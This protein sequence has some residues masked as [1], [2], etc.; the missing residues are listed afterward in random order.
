MTLSGAALNSSVVTTKIWHGNTRSQIPRC[1]AYKDVRNWNTW[2]TAPGRS[3]I[4]AT[5]CST[6]LW[7]ECSSQGAR[8]YRATAGVGHG[9]CG[10]PG[11]GRERL[12]WMTL[13]ST[14]RKDAADLNVES[15]EYPQY[16]INEQMTKF[17]R[18]TRK[19]IVIPGRYSLGLDLN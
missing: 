16:F 4:S 6:Q 13:S 11:S 12:K 7:K 1:F 8:G 15:L 9:I 14:M 2:R 18:R 10:P 3:P 17:G 5:T 19:R